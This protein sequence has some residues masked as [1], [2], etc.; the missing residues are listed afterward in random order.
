ME[1]NKSRLRQ[2][3]EALSAVFTLFAKTRPVAEEVATA[4][5]TAVATVTAA[6]T[7]V[8][9]ATTTAVAAT[10]AVTG[11]VTTA[12][13]VGTEVATFIDEKAQIELRIVQENLHTIEVPI[14]TI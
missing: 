2:L 3:C 4:A 5:V 10:A 1:Q 11:A 6:T 8:A 7:A 13:A 12:V 9:E 14:T